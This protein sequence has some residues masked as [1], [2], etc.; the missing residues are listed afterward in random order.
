MHQGSV[1]SHS[2]GE[3][4]EDSLWRKVAVGRCRDTESNQRNHSMKAK[5]RFFSLSAALALLFLP[6]SSFAQHRG[7]GGHGGGG[8]HGGGG[9]R[10]GG[11]WR[12]GG[13]DVRGAL[14]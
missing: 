11:G 9:C 5:R 8:R 12:G 13:W 7:G 1:R 4:Q 6:A 10:G 2:T 3:L 14:R